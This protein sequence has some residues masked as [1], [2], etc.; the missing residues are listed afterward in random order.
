MTPKQQDLALFDSDTRIMCDALRRAHRPIRA[1]TFGESG[2][3]WS[4]RK[5]RAIAEASNGEIL[6]TQAGYRLNADMTDQ[7]FAEWLSHWRASFLRGLYRLKQARDFRK[8]DGQSM[9]NFL[10]ECVDSESKGAQ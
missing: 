10:R 7:E 1:K 2:F 4:E 9:M 3:R 6:G 8:Q 5:C